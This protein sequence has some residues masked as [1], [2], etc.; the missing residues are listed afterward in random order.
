MKLEIS[1]ETRT[2]PAYVCR[3]SK[4]LYFSL[5]C[6]TQRKSTQFFT[7]LS[8]SNLQTFSAPVN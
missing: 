4:K 6:I 2:W 5:N 3:M 7:V 8:E 1:K